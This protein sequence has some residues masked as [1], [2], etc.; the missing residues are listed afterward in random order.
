MYSAVMKNKKDSSQPATVGDVTRIVQRI[1]RRSQEE[2]ALIFGGALNDV[3]R[4]LTTRIDNLDVKIE[5]IDNRVSNVEIKVD[6]L[7]SKVN[8]INARIDDLALNRVKY[9]DHQKLCR[10][11]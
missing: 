11:C 8:G 3:E 2:L 7:N 9:E 4:R 6:A 1:V 10:T 5:G